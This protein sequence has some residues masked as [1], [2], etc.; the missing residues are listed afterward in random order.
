LNFY[1]R[2]GYLQYKESPLFLQSIAFAKVHR[3]KGL[4]G[5]KDEAVNKEE[6]EA[7]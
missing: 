5:K 3:K 4:K 2:V 1:A 6:A 7:I